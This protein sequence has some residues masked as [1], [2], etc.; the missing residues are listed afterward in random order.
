M[1]RQD[2]DCLQFSDFQLNFL[3]LRLLLPLLVLLLLPALLALIATR[4]SATQVLFI[5]Y[6]CL[7]NLHFV[8][9]RCKR[10][11]TPP[12]RGKSSYISD[13]L[14]WSGLELP[15][16]PSYLTHA[17]PVQF[18]SDICRPLSQESLGQFY[19]VSSGT[20]STMCPS[21]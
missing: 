5:V 1:F 21:C 7:Y 15:F 19:W 11:K 20:L 16:K 8:H 4:A 18:Y 12:L 13:S 2:S 17:D 10:T 14:S 6:S 9:S 3:I